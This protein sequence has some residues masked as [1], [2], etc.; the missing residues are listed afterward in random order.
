MAWI[1]E[2]EHLPWDGV[3]LLEALAL[4]PEVRDPLHLLDLLLPLPSWGSAS[5]GALSRGRQST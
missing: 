4:F 5:L 3:Y 2:R 1:L